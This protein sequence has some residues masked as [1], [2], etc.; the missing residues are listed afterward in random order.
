MLLLLTMKIAIL[1]DEFCWESIVFDAER[2]TN[3]IPD[4]FEG[5]W[6]VLIDMHV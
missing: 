3:S 6:A 4:S 1:A 2:K 5:Y